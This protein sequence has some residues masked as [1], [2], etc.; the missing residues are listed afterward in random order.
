MRGGITWS[1]TGRLPTKNDDSF[2]TVSAT[3]NHQRSNPESP[4]YRFGHFFPSTA[5]NATSREIGSL[6]YMRQ[7]ADDLAQCIFLSEWNGGGF[8]RDGGVIEREGRRRVVHLDR[9]GVSNGR[10]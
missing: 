1:I 6:A 10:R 5:I 2:S 4:K 8:A 9:V 3:L 7:V